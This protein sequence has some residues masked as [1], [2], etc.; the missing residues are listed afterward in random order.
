V[1]KW[2]YAFG[3][4]DWRAHPGPKWSA[5]SEPGTYAD[6]EVALARALAADDPTSDYSLHGPCVV[7]RSERYP[8]W[9]PV[10][11][12]AAELLAEAALEVAH[13][14]RRVGRDVVQG[15]DLYAVFAKIANQINPSTENPQ[16]YDS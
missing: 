6:A 13:E 12:H 14:F 16:E 8:E 3:L 10:K 15:N 9:Q 7:K 5:E 11:D 1:E 2:E 4:E